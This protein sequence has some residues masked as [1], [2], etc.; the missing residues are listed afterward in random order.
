MAPDGSLD[1]VIAAFDE[2]GTALL[3]NDHRNVYL[4]LVEPFVDVVVRRESSAFF[5]AVSATPGYASSGD[6]V[7]IARGAHAFTSTLPGATTEFNVGNH[8]GMSAEEVRVPLYA[9]GCRARED[10]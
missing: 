6:Y 5:V 7:L 4:G 2:A 3:V 9:I 1:G 8:G 10:E